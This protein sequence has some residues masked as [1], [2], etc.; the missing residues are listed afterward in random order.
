MRDF[1]KL[2]L[3]LNVKHL[4]CQKLS[5]KIKLHLH[6]SHYNQSQ[7][8]GQVGNLNNNNNFHMQTVQGQ[9]HD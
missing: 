4:I 1:V 3:Q 2:F 6:N 5:S 8:H 7:C 9:K